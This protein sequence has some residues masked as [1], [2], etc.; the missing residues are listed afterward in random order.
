MTFDEIRIKAIRAANR[1]QKLGYQPGSVFALM[2]RNSKDV[3]SIVFASLFVGC[4]VN[5]LDPH[6]NKIELLNM[7]KTTKPCLMFCDIDVYDLV[8]EC[9]N[10]LG[11]DTSIFTVGGQKGCAK[12]VESLFV[13]SDDDD[14]FS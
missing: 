13:E 10:E 1:L 2:T 14:Q 12:N 6:F 11:L 9:R 4:P 3:A 8:E 7:L 5:T